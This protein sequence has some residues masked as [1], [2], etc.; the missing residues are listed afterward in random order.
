M[1]YKKTENEIRSA[2]E[3]IVPVNT[4]EKITAEISARKERSGI[5]MTKKKRNFKF[6]IPVAACFILCFGIFGGVIINNQA[7]ASVIMIDVNPSVEI[8][9][10]RNDKVLDVAPINEDGGK[11]LTD[12]DYSDAELSE[13]VDEVITSMV[14]NGYLENE[15][16]SVL[17]TVQNENEEK[18]DELGQTVAA[19][20]ESTL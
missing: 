12:A 3:E 20:I 11:I 7:V 19:E 10:N 4:F 9:V 2:F 8:S 5:I 16:N 6:L 18:A 13:V 1:G 17:V 15:N 14:Q